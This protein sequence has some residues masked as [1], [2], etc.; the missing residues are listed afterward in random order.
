MHANI[1]RKWS[2]SEADVQTATSDIKEGNFT[3][4]HKAARAYNIPYATLWHCMAGRNLRAT[5][6]QIEQIL[7]SAKE[8]T[9]SQWIT[10]L[11]CTGF[12]ASPA[13]VV[14]MAEEV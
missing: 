1:P 7:S 11:T 13:L 8:K 10:Q 9:L 6:H 5:A 12:P 4:I 2:Y 14:Q 3:S